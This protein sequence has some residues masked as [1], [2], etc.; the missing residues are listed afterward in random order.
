MNSKAKGTVHWVKPTLP[1]NL[2]G[3]KFLDIPGTDQIFAGVCLRDFTFTSLIFL[4]QF[5]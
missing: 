1:T 2:Q 3:L 5:F 4:K